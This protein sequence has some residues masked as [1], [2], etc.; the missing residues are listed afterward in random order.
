MGYQ[1]PAVCH[2]VPDEST[3]LAVFLI[4][5]H[6]HHYIPT[7]VPL[8]SHKYPMHLSNPFIAQGLIETVL[9]DPVLRIHVDV[10]GH[11]LCW[12]N[13]ARYHVSLNQ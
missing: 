1:N 6:I 10:V 5:R 4:F 7:N 12:R 9:V 3:V 2:H 11:K 13:G 8:T